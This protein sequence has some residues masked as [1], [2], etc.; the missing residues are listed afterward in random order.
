M[1]VSGCLLSEEISHYLQQIA[2]IELPVLQR[3]R[4][5]TALYRKSQM[6][7]PAETVCLLT[8]LARLIRAENYLEIGVFTGYSSTAMA[9][10]LPENG[11][12]DA[13]DINITHTQLA[14]QAWEEAKVTHKISLHLQPAWIT[15]QHLAEQQKTYDMALID[16][17]KLPIAHYFSGCLKLI[18]SGGLIVLD[19]VLLNGRVANP[20]AHSDS[21]D[22]VRAFNQALSCDSRVEVVILPLGDGVTVCM[23]N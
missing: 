19:N 20:N 5:R 8:F 4:E 15:L 18:R 11:H 2:P 17:D 23:K 22:A 12:I 14:Q 3:I 7:P 1:S 13:C 21:I 10:T 6:A 16:G 9:L